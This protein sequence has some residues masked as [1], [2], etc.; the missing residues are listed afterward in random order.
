M[1]KHFVLVSV[2]FNIFNKLFASID[3][4]EFICLA[5]TLDGVE[6]CFNV[7]AF[8][9]LGSSIVGYRVFAIFS[10]VAGTCFGKLVAGSSVLRVCF[11][12]EIVCFHGAI[13]GFC[14]ETRCF[15]EDAIFFDTPKVDCFVVDFS[16][17][18]VFGNDFK[19]S[20]LDFFLD[21]HK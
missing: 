7:F 2:H 6:D 5:D 1:P 13:V 14:K 21:L 3:A 10:D 15:G 19:I 4:C 20:R 12:L 16:D 8:F 9:E 17:L 18:E 11:D